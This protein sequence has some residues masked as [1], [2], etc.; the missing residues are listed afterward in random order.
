MK[1]AATRES[2]I[3]K[4][5]FDYRNLKKAK[6]RSRSTKRKSPSPTYSDPRQLIFEAKFEKYRANKKVREEQK[7]KKEGA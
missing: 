7:K 6:S 4:P 1:N 5:M 3:A 2:T